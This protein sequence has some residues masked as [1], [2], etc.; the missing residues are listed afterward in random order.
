MAE[1]K[2]A[3]NRLV[4][5]WQVATDPD[6]VFG[7]I[8]L[9]YYRPVFYSFLRRGFSNEVSQ[10]LAQETFLRVHKGL[11]DFR[12]ESRFETWLFQI[13]ANLFRNTLRSQST[14]KRD[15][16]EV[17]LD[18][19]VERQAEEQGSNGLIWDSKAAGPLDTVLAAER[20]E[21]LRSALEG[22]PA[23]MRRCVTLRV[24]Q[25][26]KYREIAELMRISIETVKAHLYQARQQ[27][28]VKLA[29][30]FNEN[31]LDGGDRGQ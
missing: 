9:A 14:L 7:R 21:V 10:D 4:E 1:D 11:A 30:Y 28:K 2:D 23:Q 24:E 12:C 25:D 13:A 31:D 17:S 27:L 3:G 18:E 22:L 5:E 6:E 8:F 19:A 15:A 29:D 16:P 26:L 20:V